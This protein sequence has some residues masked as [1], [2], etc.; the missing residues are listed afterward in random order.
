M[1]KWMYKQRDGQ[2]LY[3]VHRPG[4]PRLRTVLLPD[5]DDSAWDH[6]IRTYDADDAT[7]RPVTSETSD[8]AYL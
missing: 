5:Y 1:S 7:Y 2:V 6:L 8:R 3:G 4:S